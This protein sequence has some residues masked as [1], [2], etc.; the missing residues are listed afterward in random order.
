MNYSM[1]LNINENDVLC[2]RGGT[3]NSHSGNVKFRNL[4]MRH[5]AA[6]KEANTRYEKMSISDEIVMAIQTTTPPGRFLKEVEGCWVEIESEQARSKVSQAL[7][8]K[9]IYKSQREKEDSGPPTPT[10]PSTL[11][12]TIASAPAP[13]SP[14]VHNNNFKVDSL[15]S[16]EQNVYNS[17]FC[18]MDGR[19]AISLT[20][21]PVE[22]SFDTDNAHTDS[23]NSA[24]SWGDQGIEDDEGP[25]INTNLQ[26]Q[27]RFFLGP[28]HKQYHEMKRELSLRPDWRRTLKLPDANALMNE[29]FKS[30]EESVC[31]ASIDMASMDFS[32][33]AAQANLHSEEDNG[34]VCMNS[35]VNTFDTSFRFLAENKMDS[36]DKLIYDTFMTSLSSFDPYHANRNLREE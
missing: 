24:D 7:R 32:R 27:G 21:P 17:S 2:G 1:N 10:L 22:V 4:V 20:V 6:Y 25:Q 28:K 5:K 9:K 34:T 15:S 14:L 13:V 26:K 16:V 30:M 23:L 36:T 33:H 12:S 3:I 31:M 11:A 35:L 18:Q 19:A 8:E 29:S